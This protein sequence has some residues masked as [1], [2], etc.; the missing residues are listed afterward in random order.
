MQSQAL[1]R[2]MELRGRRVVEACGRLWH[3]VEGGLFMAMPYQAP[4]AP[5][6]GDIARML[7]RH[8][9]LGVRYLSSTHR[10]H[11]S[12]I[13]VCRA[14]GY[15]FS[16][17]Q[18]RMRSLVRRGL[19]E[20]VVRRVEPDQLL[21]EG[22]RLNLDSMKRQGR[23][24]PE[25]AE[26][27]SWRRLVEAIRR[28]PGITAWGSFVG[29]QLAAYVV[30]LREDG[31]LYLLHQNSRDDL[32][33]CM[34]NHALTFTVTRDAM[35]D[36]AIHTVCYGILSMVSNPGLHTYKLRIGYEVDEYD[37]VYQLHPAV[38]P[39]LASRPA[40]WALRQLR[41]RR[42]QDQRFERVE[43]VL[44]GARMRSHGPIPSGSSFEAIGVRE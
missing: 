26:P 14:R 6:Q 15:T 1:A 22:L 18:A 20:C 10:G 31:W 4:I 11:K 7:I 37:S 23:M 39:V 38:S 29:G 2:H 28:T 9:G 5:D 41:R 44:T 3:S 40:L 43:V 36:P 16:N 27:A 25:F 30:A 24:D 33:E 42:P 12:G 13:Y 8:S 19:E 17:V 32:L 34:P 35:A 21:G